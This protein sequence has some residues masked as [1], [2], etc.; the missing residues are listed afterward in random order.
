MASDLEQDAIELLQNLGLKEYEAKCFVALTRLP[1]GSA[2][3][4][5]EIAAVPRTRVY[6]AV[7]V[8]ESEG[9]VEIQHTNPQ[10]FRALSIEEATG[11]LSKR[12]ASRIESLG[13]TLHAIESRDIS[14]SRNAQEIWSLSGADAINERAQ[15][16]LAEASGEVIVV[17]GAEAVLT[18]RLYDA[19]GE[20]IDRDVD[21]LFGALSSSTRNRVRDRLPHA[22]VFETELGWLEGTSE[23]DPSIGVLVMADRNT[24]LVSSLT[25]HGPD[26]RSSET[27]IY[28]SGFSNGLVIIARRLLARGLLA[29]KDPAE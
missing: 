8:L 25:E 6:D 14:T 16:I 22:E 9:L 28:G 7:R 26:E 4:I 15:R 18:D 29:A 20:A 24:L 17:V 27:A 19:L 2:K 13:D 11:I 1:S 10:Q 12:Y 3:E 21:V 23:E 5:S